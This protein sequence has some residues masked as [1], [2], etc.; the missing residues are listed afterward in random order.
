MK[1]FLCLN[2]VKFHNL[3]LLII[4]FV[5]IVKLNAEEK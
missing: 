2:T 1:S 5:N 4:K 3:N